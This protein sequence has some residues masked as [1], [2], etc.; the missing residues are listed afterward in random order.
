MKVMPRFRN[1]SQE[2]WPVL[3]CQDIGPNLSGGGNLSTRNIFQ[4]DYTKSSEKETD[5][6]R[7]KERDKVI[8]RIY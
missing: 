7:Q 8:Q 1:T 6:D 5:R 3:S 4:A 2:K